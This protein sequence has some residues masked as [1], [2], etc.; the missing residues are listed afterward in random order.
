MVRSRADLFD[1]AAAG[2]IAGG[3]TASLF[4]AIGIVLSSYTDEAS[5]VSSCLGL[6][7]AV[8]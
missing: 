2:P 6:L 3:I 5:R 1:V 7:G 4:L 8:K